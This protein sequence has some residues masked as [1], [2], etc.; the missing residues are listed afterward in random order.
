MTSEASSSF[1]PILDEIERKMAI[2]EI[3][4]AMGK[5]EF[6]ELT[7]HAVSY[8]RFVY[9]QCRKKKFS[10]RQSMQLTLQFSKDL[11]FGG[12]KNT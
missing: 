7:E 1:D 2:G 3:R 6:W 9:D 10:R 12:F 11:F 5:R 4:D 8:S